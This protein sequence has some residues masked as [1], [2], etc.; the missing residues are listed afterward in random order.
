MKI[1]NLCITGLRGVKT[2]LKID[3]QGKSALFYG[4]NGTGK[5]TIADVL[6]WLYDDKIEHLSDA[7]IGTK[8]YPAIRNIDLS[9]DKVGK[10]ELNISQLNTTVT[11]TIEIKN[12]TTKSNLSNKEYIEASKNE[13]FILRYKELN[14]F[15]TATKTKRLDALSS[16]IGYS[17]VTKVK[18]EL[19]KTCNT[20]KKERDNKNFQ[21]Q[22][23]IQQET[24]MSAFDCTITNDKQFLEVVN[25][26][27]NPFS[28]GT[29]ASTLQ[30]ING[31]LE[32]IKQP[33]DNKIAIQE[34]FLKKVNGTIILLPNKLDELGGKYDVYKQAFEAIASDIDKLKKLIFEQL[35]SAGKIILEDD[36]YTDAQCPL[37]L[38]EKNK[39]EL[40]D[41]IKD[42]LAELETI[43]EEQTNLNQLKRDL[44]QEIDLCL[45]DITTTL[46][47]TIINEAEN[48]EYKEKFIKLKN[49]IEKYQTLLQAKPSDTQSLA[50]K[51]TLLI[52]KE[53]LSSMQKSVEVKLSKIQNKRSDNPKLD[54]FYK[55]KSAKDAYVAINKFKKEEAVYKTQLDTIEKIYK[56]FLEC[57]KNA[58]AQFFDSF[59]N[60]IN[61]I[62]NFLSLDNKMENIKLMPAEKD[63][64]LTGITLE[65]DFIGNKN[66]S[67]PHKFL[68]ESYL[69]RIGI[70]LFL[71]SVEAFNK[72][73]KFIIL[74]D[75]ISSFDTPHRKKFADLLIEKY[76]S[77][78]LIVLTHEEFWFQ[79]MQN[80]LKGKD[81][82]V[83]TIKY[84][85]IDGTYID[86][87]EKLIRGR[88]EEKITLGNSENLA[89]D[90]RKYL[91]QSLKNI[92]HALEVKLSFRFNEKNEDRMCNEL[93][94]ALKGT[95]NKKSSDV[96]KEPIFDRLIR[97]NFI[98]NRDS[99]HN[100]QSPSF[101]DMA[102]YW[103]AVC[104]FENLFFCKE[105]KTYI[106]VKDYDET[107]KKAH[108][109]EKH[110]SIPWEK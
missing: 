55:I 33:E 85:D 48:N 70:A 28:L 31:V 60:R 7:E 80:N 107:E 42:K 72:K 23:S 35:F 101:G 8:G 24:V 40:L 100:N 51:A 47:E 88:I 27:I 26:L 102:A 38:T 99:H 53:L 19:Q 74:D 95:L 98:G 46:G 5:S 54:A 2:E 9:D 10:I 61:E 89:H 43:K 44:S 84:N 39:S 103:S 105:C 108:C 66:I 71:A 16:I 36:S 93:L 13:S 90:I 29:E 22:I 76:S 109:K 64:E 11:K 69:N 65:L 15:V 45:G 91:E 77:Y 59:S 106:S 92:A 67:P 12:D 1:N 14:N 30:E 56:T 49:Q 32:A 50:D 6:E 62:C 58:L 3:L 52:D 81:W 96:L 87:A 57:Q 83:N 86:E 75:A 97:S 18:S 17:E 68:S 34:T 78:Q 4:D 63:D 41:L 110:I 20:L 82:L 25:E 104:E 21:G 73:N 79:L 94:S 37:C